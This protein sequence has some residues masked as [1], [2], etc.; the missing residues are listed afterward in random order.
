MAAGA[1]FLE[2]DGGGVGALDGVRA[3]LFDQVGERDEHLGIAGFVE[4]RRQPPGLAPDRVAVAGGKVV[5]AAEP[6][7]PAGAEGGFRE[8]DQPGE[9][10]AQAQASVQAAGPELVGDE[11]GRGPV[12]RCSVGCL[13][14]PAAGRRVVGWDSPRYTGR[15]WT[16]PE[17]HGVVRAIVVDEVVALFEPGPGPAQVGIR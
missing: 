3:A 11:E 14:R 13:S 17:R 10:A 4:V 16:I 8:A 2:A 12:S 9:L 1:A 7:G 5:L 15:G 6:A